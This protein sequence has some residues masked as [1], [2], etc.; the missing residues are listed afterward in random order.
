MPRPRT[1]DDDAVLDAADRIVER[2]GPAAVTF[3]SVA[4]EVGLAPATLVQRFGTKR[5]LLLATTIRG[6]QSIVDTLSRERDARESPLQALLAALAELTADVRT[7][8]ALANGLAALHI[9]LS[10]PE[11]HAHAVTG[12]TRMRDRIADL[13]SDAISAGELIGEADPEQL[14]GAILTTYNG[15]LIT[16]AMYGEGAVDEYVRSQLEFL[17]GAWRQGPKRHR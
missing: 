11:F 6:W 9:D 3:A 7:R 16:W 15:A 12:A 10:D 1:I 5:G 14:A 13:L 2:G 17:L 4:A 8:E